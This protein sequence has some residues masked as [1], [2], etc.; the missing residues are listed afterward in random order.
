MVLLQGVPHLAQLLP[1]ITQVFS[2]LAV[3][4]ERLTPGTG[5]LSTGLVAK[6]W[7]LPGVD[8]ILWKM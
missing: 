3:Q 4:A 6:R 5:V 7:G 2:P 8:Q 1:G